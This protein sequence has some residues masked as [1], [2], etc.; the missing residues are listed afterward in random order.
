MTSPAADGSPPSSG[1]A[2]QRIGEREFIA[3]LAAISAT[4]ALGIDM[5][6][7]AFGEIRAGLGLPV[8]S[9]R[10]ALTV[11]LYFLGLAFGQIPYGPFADRFG[12]KPV[13]YAGLAIYGLGAVG[14]ALA[15]NFGVLIA[16]RFLWGL[17]AAGPRSLSLA[18]ARDLHTGDPLARILQL[19][20]AVFMVVPAFAPLLG[21]GVLAVAGWRFN[22]GAPL[23]LTIALMLWLRRLNETL[24]D[25][26]RRPLTLARTRVAAGAVIS[27]RRSMAYAAAAMFDLGSFAVFLGSGELIFGAA[28]DRS[29]QFAYAFG[30]MSLVM[31]L[32][33]WQ[34]SR[35]VERFGSDR[36]IS[37]FMPVSIVLSAALLALALAADGQPN[38]WLWFGLVTI[39]NS[40]RTMLTPL[41]MATAMEPMGELAGT[42]SGVIGTIALGGGAL[43]AG[44]VDTQI[45]NTVTPL[46]AAYLGYGLCTWLAH[47]AG[48]RN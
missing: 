21:E 8:D 19:V 36:L 7:P 13:L 1:Q 20:Q 43:L 10:V 26:A 45:T 14:S 35:W 29:S 6:L 48:R 42:A 16:F 40:L 27:N 33:V 3:L 32:F 5:V 39:V 25:D 30:G 22:L 38:F 11:T 47:L 2:N 41:F 28:Y 23:L 15:P 12:R 17:G 34:G 18:V 44:V 31:G 24:P 37:M 46:V 4:T 9:N